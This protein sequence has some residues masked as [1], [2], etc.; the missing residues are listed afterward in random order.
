M[1]GL[2]NFTHFISS[3][4]YVAIFALSVAQSCCFPTSSELT[5]GF[6]GALAAQGKLNLAAV[7]G[8][9]VAGE[10]VGAYIAWYVGRTAG[11]AVV[12][13]WGKYLLLTHHD[14][15]RAEAW[16]D[17]HGQ[18][19]VLASRCVPFIRNF[20]AVPAGV[21]EVPA[22]RFG[23]L[24]GVG[25]LIWLGSMAGIGYGVG[26]QWNK[27]VHDFSDA[28]YVIAV[29]VVLAI[30]FV[31]WHRYRS[32]KSSSSAG[33]PAHR[34][35]RPAPAFPDQVGIAGEAADTTAPEVAPPI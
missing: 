4:G 13:R 27:I 19:G 21:A 32:Y 10:V 2:L 22:V 9:G 11:R 8:V 16:Y 1:L 23:L 17:R 6:A 12:D 34:L 20:V 15:D 26:S 7:I 30:A 25:S 29:L 33:V 35:S 5:L 31:I 24:T 14:L 28:G 3:W 18:W